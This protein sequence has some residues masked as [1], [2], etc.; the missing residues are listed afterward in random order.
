MRT[1]LAIIAAFIGLG[2]FGQTNIP[3]RQMMV[4]TNGEVKWPTN[5]TSITIGG[6]TYTNLRGFGLTITNGQLS[7]D[8][9]QLPVG[10]G[11]SGLVTSVSSDFEVDA[12]ELSVTNTVGT[13][14]LLR[15][16]EA[17]SGGTNFINAVSADFQ[18]LA[19]SLSLTNTTGTGAILRASTL[20]PYLL[21]ATAASTYATLDS[22]SFTGTASFEFIDAGEVQVPFASLYA[23]ANSSSNLT[24][25]I[26][27]G[28]WTN[29]NG[30]SIATGTVA[31]ARIDSA[32]ATDAE[33][34]A[35]FA[36]LASPALTG[37]PTV[38]TASAGLS[39][40]VAASTAY[41]DRAVASGGGGGGG[42]L[43]DGGTASSLT[44]T[45]LIASNLNGVE[46]YN[47][48]AG[49]VW[50]DGHTTI[51][52]LVT[53]LPYGYGAALASGT[54]VS[55]TG[56]TNRP[57]IQRLRSSASANSGFS[58]YG[59]G[60]GIILGGSEFT[61]LLVTL[62][63]TN[64]TVVRFGFLDSVTTTE[65]TDGAYF[66]LANGWLYGMTANNSSRTPSTSSN[67]VAISSTS[68][69]RLRIRVNSAA[70]SVNFQWVTATAPG[71]F[72]TNLNTDIT[73]TIPTTRATS[74][75]FVVYNVPGG[76]ADQLYVDAAGL[77]FNRA[78]TR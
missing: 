20:S 31:A 47:D 35:T 51:N 22:P 11:G 72:T 30:S 43:S 53:F 54:S 57:S 23:S 39:N 13:G 29:L 16:S 21:S 50:S 49:D 36:P 26:D 74:H 44:V 78:Q 60:E 41:V 17:G 65:P 9:S 75:G 18:V 42:G 38:P 7:V 63:A 2:A 15:Q 64:G 1:I 59:S 28:S 37:S 77:K 6:T 55:G 33:V 69:D 27:G 73:S 52:S 45:N 71:V 14:P 70:S 32:M 25:T 67:L 62:C 61:E 3:T 58:Y 19:A 76:A 68:P 5:I 56:T 48:A 66:E 46:L 10:S 8:T 40:T 24:G 12:G 4:S 34:A